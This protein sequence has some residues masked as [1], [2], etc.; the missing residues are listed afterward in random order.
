MLYSIVSLML[1]VHE[2]LIFGP[3]YISKDVVARLEHAA[4]ANEPDMNTKDK[5][6]SLGSNRLRRSS[7]RSDSESYLRSTIVSISR[8]PASDA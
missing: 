5:T 1:H 7:N 3:K 8:P 4:F 2:L 6:N